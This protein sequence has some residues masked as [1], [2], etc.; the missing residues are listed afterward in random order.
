MMPR[1][2]KTATTTE[3]ARLCGVSHSTV[4]KW[5]DTGLIEGFRLPGSGD[6]RLLLA[7]LHKFMKENNIPVPETIAGEMYKVLVVDDDP[8]V[9]KMFQVA[10][11]SDRF[12]VYAASDGYTAGLVTQ[13]TRPHVIIL[14][15][16]LPDIDGRKVAESIRKNVEG[17]DGIIYAI[18]GVLAGEK[19]IRDLRRHGIEYFEKKP[20]DVAQFVKKIGDILDERFGG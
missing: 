8:R 17:W 1:T 3:A 11:P 13:K 15:I 4:I 16:S 20:F 12:E 18:S 9:H 10:F 7:S 14:D 2:K 6:R 5:F 19:E